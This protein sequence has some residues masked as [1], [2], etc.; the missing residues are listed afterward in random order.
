[1]ITVGENSY[2]SVADAD[3]Y[4]TSRIDAAAWSAADDVLKQQAL[5]TASFMLNELSWIGVATSDVQQLAFPRVGSYFEQIL[6]R[7]VRLDAN[8]IPNRIKNATYEQAYQLLNNDGL[9]DDSGTLDEIK[10]DVIELKGLSSG[11]AQP[12]RFSTTARRQFEPLLD[13]SGV[14]NGWWRAN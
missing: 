14:R 4:F 9:L 8:A 12:N 2:V 6:G 11:S 1:M 13:Q 5:V 7:V 10:V 3:A